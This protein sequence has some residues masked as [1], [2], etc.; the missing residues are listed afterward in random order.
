MIRANGAAPMK[1]IR[2]VFYKTASGREPVREWLK[3]QL[4]QPDSITV[5]TDI[6]TVEYGWP[7][8]MPLARPL[9]RGLFEIR[10]ALSGNRTA[11]V[12]FCVDNSFM[13][14]LHGFIK[15]TRETPLKDIELALKR[16]QELEVE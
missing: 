16:K 6:R 13:F 2:A 14:L 9:G 7:V 5:G 3:E 4:G 1:R 15:K 8:G 12:I 10:T 11:R